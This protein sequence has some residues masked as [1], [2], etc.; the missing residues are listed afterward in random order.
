MLMRLGVE[1]LMERAERLLPQIDSIFCGTL[2]GKEA[3]V[4]LCEGKSVLVGLTGSKNGEAS[5]K[6]LIESLKL[7]IDMARK[8]VANEKSK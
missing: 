7:S 2:S 4:V 8:E 3:R 5:V 6:L 1:A